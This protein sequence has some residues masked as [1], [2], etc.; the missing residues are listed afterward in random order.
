M[1]NLVT[2]SK[3]KIALISIL[4]LFVISILSIVIFKLNLGVEYMDATVISMKLDHEELMSNIGPKAENYHSV[5]K[6]EKEGTNSFN[7]YLQGISQEA[8]DNMMQNLK[9]D[10]S[11]IVSIKS[12]EYFTA[13]EKA[14]TARAEIL[15]G[16]G[17]LCLSIYIFANIKN[18][19]FNRAQAIALWGTQMGVIL[20]NVVILLGLAS[21]LGVLNTVMDTNFWS[22]FL[23]CIGIIVV[24][25]IYEMLK[26]R[27]ILKT[28][29]VDGIE[30]VS[31]KV[32]KLYWPEFVFISCFIA[33]VTI[34]PLVVLSTNILKGTF[35]VL[36]TIIMSLAS[37]IYL[38]PYI[39]EQFLKVFDSGFFKKSGF[40]SKKW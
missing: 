2:K 28:L 39:Q 10:I 20:V 7:I 9:S 14:L 23:L 36:F 21:F 37:V 12:Y 5:S 4:V 11:G 25:R 31:Q 15:I 24:Y 32:I 30:D 26:E 33:L 22:I 19:K 13:R 6:V 34:L 16:F 27:M 3:T 1:A 35:M 8:T 38:K 17:I 29:E 18:K 40:L